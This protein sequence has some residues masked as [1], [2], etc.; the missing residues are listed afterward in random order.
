M[1]NSTEHPPQHSTLPGEYTLSSSKSRWFQQ[2]SGSSENEDNVR[3]VQKASRLSCCTT[4]SA[5]SEAQAETGGGRSRMVVSGV[6]LMV[7]SG[8]ETC[9]IT[10]RPDQGRK[11][12]HKRDLVTYQQV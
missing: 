12:G 8:S 4:N 1:N 11:T 5:H 3:D 9:T 2:P 6:T 10:A 7:Q